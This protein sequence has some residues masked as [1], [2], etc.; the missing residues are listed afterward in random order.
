MAQFLY[1]CDIP[2]S[3]I[4]YPYTINTPIE[5][6]TS[7]RIHS[8]GTSTAQINPSQQSSN[9]PSHHIQRRHCASNHCPD[10]LPHGYFSRSVIDATEGI[11]KATATKHSGNWERLFTF[12]SHA[13]V[14]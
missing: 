11:S 7:S 1:G 4:R 13:S 9:P 10:R 2:S 12:L 3:E 14:K 5:P 6:K 8:Q